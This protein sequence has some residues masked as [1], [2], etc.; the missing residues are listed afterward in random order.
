MDETCIPFSNNQPGHL[1][2]VVKII[3]FKYLWIRF[4]AAEE[5]DH[6]YCFDNNHVSAYTKY[7]TFIAHGPEE[8]AHADSKVKPEDGEYLL[9]KFV[10]I[11]FLSIEHHKGLEAEIENLL[12]AT[13]EVRD[14][15]AY[16]VTRERAHRNG[17]LPWQ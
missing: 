15:Q 10:F 13:R 1:G 14:E 6:H 7:L 4:N 12:I 5:G 8:R 11:S 16:F 2:N 9:L 3:S 17:N